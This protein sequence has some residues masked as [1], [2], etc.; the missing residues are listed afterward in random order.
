MAEFYKEKFTNFYNEYK[1]VLKTSQP[2]L[3]QKFSK[4]GWLNGTNKLEIQELISKFINQ[5]F[6]NQVLSDSQI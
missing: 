1:I 6:G 3:F 4:E 2:T 5:I